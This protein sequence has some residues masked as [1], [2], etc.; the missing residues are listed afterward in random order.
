MIKI[1]FFIDTT[2]AS[3]GAEK[4]LRELVNNMDQSKFDITVHTLWKEDAE[5]YLAPGIR[6][7]YIFDR[8]TTWNAT[9]FRIESALGLTYRMHLSDDYD[10]E[11]AY[12]EYGPTKVL[13]SSANK[14]ARKVAWIHCNLL[15]EIQNLDGFV[16]R[17]EKWYRKYDK[18]VCVSQMIHDGYRKL[19][20]DQPES[21]KLY[22]TVDDTAIRRKAA[23]PLPAEI[24]KRKLTVATIGRLYPV[25]GYD[26]LMEAHLRLIREGLKHDL[27]ILGEGSDRPKM[28]KYILEHHLEGSVHLL[29]FHSN[30]YPFMRE[31]DVI[32]CSSYSEGFSTMVTEAL[33]L[34]RPVVTTPCSGMRELLGDS[35]YGIITEDSTEG[36]YE[37]LKMML[38]NP[39]LRARYAR[40]AA[41]RGKEFSK[42]K[43]VAETEAFFLDLL[44][45]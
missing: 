33:I 1:L 17:A 18:V 34:G 40:A 37:G 2:L 35:E 10:I 8:K 41:V 25:K 21:V 30:P 22:N 20:G 26:R 16:K 15:K 32:V 42:E 29:G 9:R 11:V 24:D 5:K 19:F 45:E 4:V 44:N 39:A 36:I 6:Y 7:R 14:K 38:D 31:A 43:L 27:W 13:A 12:L 23:D 28:E 3:G